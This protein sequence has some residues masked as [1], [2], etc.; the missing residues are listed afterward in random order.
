MNW[1]RIDNM[2]VSWSIE[3]I[4]NQINNSTLDP[5][6]FATAGQYNA[7]RHRMQD[8]LLVESN[9]N[10]W[11]QDDSTDVIGYDPKEDAAYDPS[12][13]LTDDVEYYNN[14]VK[15]KK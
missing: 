3:Q 1:R 5:P 2:L 4:Q 9:R 6:I 11:L 14:V 7:W 12:T 13:E 15:R 10:G 8:R